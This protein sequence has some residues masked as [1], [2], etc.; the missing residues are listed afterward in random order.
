MKNLRSY[1]NLESFFFPNY[2]SNIRAGILAVLVIVTTVILL[3][4]F[5]WLY[6]VPAFL[7]GWFLGL[8]CTRLARYLLG[9]RRIT[10]EFIFDEKGALYARNFSGTR[11]DWDKLQELAC[12]EEYG[13]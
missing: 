12:K 8:L 6:F 7:G 11:A 10:S 2:S 13:D 9:H 1:L 3:L 5:P 4:S